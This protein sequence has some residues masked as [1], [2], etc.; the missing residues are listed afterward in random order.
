MDS[1]YVTY[2]SC[3]VQK[4][5]PNTFLEPLSCFLLSQQH[6]QSG[7]CNITVYYLFLSSL[8]FRPYSCLLKEHRKNCKSC[9][10]QD[11]ASSWAQLVAV[12]LC[13]AQGWATGRAKARV[14]RYPGP[15][16]I[17]KLGRGFTHSLRLYTKATYSTS[18]ARTEERCWQIVLKGKLSVV[19][20]HQHLMI[21]T[22]C[23]NGRLVNVTDFL[24][25]RYLLYWYLIKNN[26]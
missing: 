14:H 20:W 19:I 22:T 7:L 4:P 3:V 6:H 1:S 2:I 11:T 25:L 12:I 10:F 18:S 21:F 15:V 17:L 16:P 26:L 13:E 9:H 8:S 23:Q 5:F 24:V